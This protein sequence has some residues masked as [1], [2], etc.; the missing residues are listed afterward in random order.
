MVG[1]AVSP[2][3]SGNRV[4]V[5]RL[6]NRWTPWTVISNPCSAF[7]RCEISTHVALARRQV[8]IC[9]KCSQSGDWNAFGLVFIQS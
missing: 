4:F 1:L 9:S 7:N 2:N 6:K 8:R 3:P 5:D